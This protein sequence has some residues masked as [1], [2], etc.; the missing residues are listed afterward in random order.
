MSNGVKEALKE[1]ARVV[2]IGIIGV[3]VAYLIDLP[4]TE[5]VAIVLLVLRT[6]DKY[7]HA[8]K[9]IKVSGIIP[10]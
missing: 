8:N 3:A 1:L 4:Q 2:L 10:F 5:T 7:V 9:N 6:A